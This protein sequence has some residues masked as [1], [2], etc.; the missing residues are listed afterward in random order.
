MGDDNVRGLPKKQFSSLRSKPS[1]PFAFKPV[2]YLLKSETSE[3]KSTINQW[4]KVKDRKPVT[5]SPPSGYINASP[6]KSISDKQDVQFSNLDSRENK[7]NQVIMESIKQEHLINNSN[8]HNQTLEKVE[9]TRKKLDS[10]NDYKIGNN[11]TPQKTYKD[12]NGKDINPNLKIPKISFRLK[13]LWTKSKIKKAYRNSFFDFNI[14]SDNTFIYFTYDAQP[15]NGLIID[16]DVNFKKLYFGEECFIISLKSG[17]FLIAYHQGRDEDLRNFFKSNKIWNSNPDYNVSLDEIENRKNFLKESIKNSINNSNTNDNSES[18]VLNLSKDS[19]FRATRAKT[20][21]LNGIS[22]PIKIGEPDLTMI[23]RQIP[24]KFVPDLK[25]KFNNNKFFTITYS[26]FKTLYNNEWINDSMI[27]FFIQY[28]I[29]LAIKNSNFFCYDQIYAFNSFFFTKLMSNSNVYDTPNYYENIKRWLSKFDFMSY[30]YIILPINENL[31]WYCCIIRGLPDLLAY[32]KTNQLVIQVENSQDSDYLPQGQE[33]KKSIVSDTGE[34]DSKLTPNTETDSTVK[35]CADI[36]VFDSLGHKHSNISNPLKS[37]IIDYCQDIHKV[38]IPKTSIRV[39]NV[40]VPRQSNFNDCGLHVIFNVRKWLQHNV[41][42]EKM[43]K[44]THSKQTARV[45][46]DANERSNMRKQLQEIM[47]DLHKHQDETEAKEDVLGVDDDVEVIEYSPSKNENE[48]EKKNTSS[49]NCSDQKI[50]A[51]CELNER[52]KLDRIS[53]SNS[54][55]PT[56][57]ADGKKKDRESSNHDFEPKILKAVEIKS[58]KADSNKF[59]FISE[60]DCDLENF[61]SKKQDNQEKPILI[62]SLKKCNHKLTLTAED[63]SSATSNNQISS[64][65]NSQKVVLVPDSSDSVETEY[66]TLDPKSDRYSKKNQLKNYALHQI[67]GL[68]QLKPHTIEKLNTVFDKTNINLNQ[69]QIQLVSRYIDEVNN[70][71]S[72]NLDAITD[73]LKLDLQ[74]VTPSHINRLRDQEFVITDSSLTSE[75][76]DINDSAHGVSNL[77]IDNSQKPEISSPEFNFQSNTLLVIDSK[78]INNISDSSASSNGSIS[79]TFPKRRKVN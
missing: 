47:I 34:G 8:I 11:P 46:F 52:V 19:D 76:D 12:I 40:R 58:N 33:S 48:T 16:R 71:T 1:G 24:Y 10:L 56:D 23:P 5:I 9:M 44:G 14:N 61:T 43:W 50:K 75:T 25:H 20:K 41:E 55:S 45:I 38:R 59:N 51:K 78:E 13:S 4:W 66:S 67:F 6:P 70:A 15:I 22:N 72:C 60:N 57:I 17:D 2:N 62:D 3:D 27:D 18:D 74:S 31:H 73:K 64:N 37:F 29:D 35:K 21:Q 26:D 36:F 28:E 54:L 30:P 65:L 7:S 42:L 49:I 69:S 79:T 63:D 53:D 77:Q 39:L 32:A 68:S